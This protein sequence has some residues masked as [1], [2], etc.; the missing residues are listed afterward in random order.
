[1]FKKIY[2]KV[3][4]VLLSLCLLLGFAA[5]PVALGQDSSVYSRYQTVPFSGG[6]RNVQ[7]VYVDLKDPSIRIEAEIAG[8]QINSVDSLANIATRCNGPG[9]EAVAAINGG[10]FNAYQTVRE[11]YGAIQKQGQFIHLGNTGTS[12][13]FTRDNQVFMDSLFV[14]I[15]GGVNG[16]YDW[17]NNW[18]AWGINHHY[19]RPD[20]ISIFTSAYG[21]VT[22]YHPYTSVVVED[23]RVVEV[24]QGQARIPQNGYTIVFGDPQWLDRFQ[25]GNE[26]SY[27]LEYSRTDF[28]SGYAQAG[29]PIWWNDMYTTLGAGPRL[30]KNGMIIAN[31]SAEGFKEDKINT[32]RA[33]RSFIGVRGDNVLIMGTVSNVTLYELAE[34]AKNMGLVEAMNLDG[35]ASSG[36][37]YKGQYLKKPGRPISNALVV[38]RQKAPTTPPIKVVLDGKAMEFDPAPISENGRTLVPMRAV[39]EAMGASV[40]WDA[41]SNTVIAVR[42]DTAIQM[43]IGSPLAYINDEAYT[44]DVPGKVVQ[45]RTMVP[46]RFIGEAFDC[47]VKWEG[48]TRTVIISS[49]PEPA[50]MGKS[51]LEWE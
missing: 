18:Y 23:G 6:Q 29:S 19:Y 33:Q 45:N 7:A 22:G 5:I 38:T 2:L 30:L 41:D 27:K 37:Y 10:Y 14:T 39:F 11:P 20:A 50:S 48:E 25:I 21:P 9:V 17:P 4:S 31:G 32:T 36:L 46:L 51:E 3:G 28:S 24:R 40:D 13:G 44:L 26:V 15:R 34:I 43:Q 35:G 8:G 1:M 16:S 47:D 49:P 42:D 12:I